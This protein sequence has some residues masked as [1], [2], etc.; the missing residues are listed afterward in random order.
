MGV[1]VLAI[2]MGPCIV[3]GLR[4]CSCLCMWWL[5]RT[6]IVE[7]VLVVSE[8]AMATYI[9]TCTCPESSR[10]R[11]NAAKSDLPD[12]DKTNQPSTMRLKATARPPEPTGLRALSNGRRPVQTVQVH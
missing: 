8:S 11:S 6:K 7:R 10:K 5:K 3:F 12:L 2:C 1:L 9:T 4:F